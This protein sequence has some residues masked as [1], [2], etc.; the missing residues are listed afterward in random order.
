MRPGV[1]KSPHWAGQNYCIHKLQ[2]GRHLLSAPLDPH[3]RWLRRYLIVRSLGG[4]PFPPSLLPVATN[5]PSACSYTWLS[6]SLWARSIERAKWI[7]L[8][9]RKSVLRRTT[10]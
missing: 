10:K 9:D 5:W 1:A 8:T 2:V 7:A 4:G 3:L 6:F